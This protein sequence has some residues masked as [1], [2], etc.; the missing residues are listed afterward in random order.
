VVTTDYYH[1]GLMEH[2]TRGAVR[3]Y[4]AQFLLAARASA[5]ELREHLALVADGLLRDFPGALFLLDTSPVASREVRFAAALGEGQS[6]A[7]LL[8]EAFADAAA[9][10]GR[11][12]QQVASGHARN[13]V[14]LYGLFRMAE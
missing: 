5:P 6:F 14:H 13:R 12:W 3:P 9:R 11:R 7:V 1:I 4:H 8:N 2:C 10:A